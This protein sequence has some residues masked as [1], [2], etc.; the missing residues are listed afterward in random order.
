MHSTLTHWTENT[1]QVS[2]PIRADTCTQVHLQFKLNA[3]MSTR[4]SCKTVNKAHTVL[5]PT[6]R[7]TKTLVYSFDSLINSSVYK[8]E[9]SI[10]SQHCI[11]SSSDSSYACINSWI[12]RFDDSIVSLNDPSTHQS[13]HSTD[14][15]TPWLIHYTR[16]YLQSTTSTHTSTH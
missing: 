12:H 6:S 16:S 9:S 15:S 3:P 8:L 4:T 11:D 5:L 14:T 13:T 2:A 10:D 1:K 7:N